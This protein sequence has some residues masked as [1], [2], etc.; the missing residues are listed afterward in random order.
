MAKNSRLFSMMNTSWV[1][2]PASHDQTDID[3]TI[4]FEIGAGSVLLKPVVDSVLGDVASQ[5]IS[6]FE[7]RCVLITE[8]QKTLLTGNGSYDA[9]SKRPSNASPLTG[10]ILSR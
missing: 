3:F 5:Q 10:R 1:L 2:L 9:R 7:K 8:K 6:A 4:E